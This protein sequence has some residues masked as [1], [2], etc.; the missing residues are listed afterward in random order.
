M[1]IAVLGTGMVG[2]TIATKLVERGHEVRMGSRDAKNP[3][4]IEWAKTVG[5]KASVGTFADA[6]K[7]G[8]LVFNCTEGAHSLDALKSAGSQTLEGKILVDVSNALDLSKGMPPPLFVNPNAESL[9]ERIQSAFPKAR[10]V[11]SVNTVSSSL[12]TDPSGVPGDHDLFLSG[13]DAAAKAAVA[14]LF[15]KEF[16]W[17]KQNI[18]DLGDVSSARAAEALFL[19]WARLWG[20]FGHANFNWHVNVGPKPNA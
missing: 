5:S 10:V 19:A 20:A 16:G 15:I 6:A 7:F 1:K 4:A 9:A 17:K 18:R 12:M 8:N 2:Q 14:D 3:K 13:N 11:K